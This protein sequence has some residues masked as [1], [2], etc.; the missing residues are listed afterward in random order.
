MAASIRRVAAAAWEDRISR[1]C[2]VLGG[3]GLWLAVSFVDVSFLVLVLCA[4][5]ALW[6]HRRQRRFEPAPDDDW[7]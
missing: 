5:G 6:Y 3:I 7:L 4:A 1:W 2:V